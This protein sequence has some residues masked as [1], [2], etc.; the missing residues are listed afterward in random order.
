MAVTWTGSAGHG[1]CF[2][3]IR[4]SL[5]IFFISTWAPM[6]FS[7]LPVCT[8]CITSSFYYCNSTLFLHV[9]S[10]WAFFTRQWPGQV[11][12]L[13]LKPPTFFTPLFL[14][15]LLFLIFAIFKPRCAFQTQTCALRNAAL[16]HTHLTLQANYLIQTLYLTVTQLNQL[17]HRCHFYLIRP[18]FYS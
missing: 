18:Q 14:C 15:F 10:F 16:K 1:F 9:N 11:S 8:S 17:L 6:K 3:L 2:V 7:L 5:Y 4:L 12:V 13:I